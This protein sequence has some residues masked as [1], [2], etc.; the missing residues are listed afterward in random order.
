M[1]VK[2]CLFFASPH[3]HTYIGSYGCTQMYSCEYT[4]RWAMVQQEEGDEVPS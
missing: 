2:S 4:P 1:I 3:E